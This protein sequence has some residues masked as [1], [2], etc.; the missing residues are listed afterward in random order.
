M[1]SQQQANARLTRFEG[2]VCIVTGAGQGIGRASALRLAAEGG[3][4]VIAER[5]ELTAAETMALVAANGGAART[6]I[7]DVS[8]P[9]EAERLMRETIAAFGRI[10]VL[11]NCVGGTIWWQPFHEYTVPQIMLELERSLHTT[12][13]CCNAVLPH[14]L[15]QGSGSIVNL[16]SSV[17]K[18][19]LYRVPYAV[20][21][22]GVEALT[23]TLAAEYGRHGI[24]VN[25]VS[26]GTTIIHDRKTS[27]LTLRPGEDANA[28]PG[29]PERVQ[30]ARRLQQ[31]MLERDGTPEEIAAA[32][33]FL[34][35]QD[36]SFITGHMI[37]CSGGGR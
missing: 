8:I 30:E 36:A 29:T 20:S 11:V 15:A 14:M 25:G 23:S 3:S 5:I 17:T 21:K 35:S 18:G 16:G 24:R 19:G 26:P 9:E 33:A 37:D 34:A 6:V 1:V 7:A 31:N 4:I 2:Q 10:D 13:W 12:L 28:I 27:R 32:V 22:G